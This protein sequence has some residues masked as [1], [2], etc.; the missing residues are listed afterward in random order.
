MKDQLDPTLNFNNTEIAFSYKSNK[1]LI[2]T[3]R[4]FQFMNK[5]TLLK[6]GT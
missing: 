2:H 1:E 6:L 3:Y 4:L 5:P